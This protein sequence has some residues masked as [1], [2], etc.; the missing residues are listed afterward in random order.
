MHGA[1]DG[2]S[3]CMHTARAQPAATLAS[4][5]QLTVEARQRE[6]A[7]ASHVHVPLVGLKEKKG[8]R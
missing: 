1:Q 4:Q 8:E 7:V 2:A 5:Q 6:A 3:A